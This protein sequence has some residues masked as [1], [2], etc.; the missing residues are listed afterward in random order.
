MRRMC[1]VTDMYLNRQEWNSGRGGVGKEERVGDGQN[2]H[3]K[4]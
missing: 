2:T 4:G 1:L 3:A